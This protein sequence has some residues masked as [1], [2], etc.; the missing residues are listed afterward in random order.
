MPFTLKLGEISPADVQK[1]FSG[2]YVRGDH[3]LLKDWAYVGACGNG[4]MQVITPSADSLLKTK[5]ITLHLDW[6]KL[7][8]RNTT[9]GVVM[10][11]KSGKR[12]NSKGV[13]NQTASPRSPL[14][15][16]KRFLS[17]MP[18]ILKN[19]DKVPWDHPQ[20]C[21]KFL[22]QSP[23]N[24]QKS[25]GMVESGKSLWR[26]VD[27][28]YSISIGMFSKYPTLWLNET[29]VGEF[30]TS[31]QVRVFDPLFHQEIHDDLVKPGILKE[32]VVA[33]AK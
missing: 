24:P 13:S 9:D 21:I 26:A 12:Q 2:T 27:G 1:Y 8:M 11:W 18:N 7:F 16:V 14:P 32:V 31:T 30:I 19:G 25:I 33:N 20:E 28:L 10:L 3:E 4:N 17:P 23:P 15:S 22:R 6:P 29:A 5:D